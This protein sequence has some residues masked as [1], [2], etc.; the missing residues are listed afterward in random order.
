MRTTL[1]IDERLLQE[2]IK[3]TKVATKRELVRLS[4]EELI[5]QKRIER[6]ISSLGKFPLKLSSEELERM[7]NDE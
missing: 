1:D 5:R 6:L 4:L 3:L 2:A 7:R